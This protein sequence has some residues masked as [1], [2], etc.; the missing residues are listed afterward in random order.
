M[1]PLP[2]PRSARLKA[3]AEKF[4]ARLNDGLAAVAF[5]LAIAVF[6]SGTYRTIELLQMEAQ[7]HPPLADFSGLPTAPE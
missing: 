6:I 5:V 3:H 7:D 4:C 1:T 2:M